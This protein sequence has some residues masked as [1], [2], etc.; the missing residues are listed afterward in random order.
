MG[1]LNVLMDCPLWAEGYEIQRTT[2]FDFRRRCVDTLRDECGVG[3]MNEATLA[4]ERNLFSTLFITT[5]LA[6]G[7]SAPKARFYAMANQCIRALVTG[8]DNLLDDE[9]KEVIQFDFSGSG[10]RFRSV[11]TVMVADRVLSDMA[12]DELAAGR[13]SRKQA[14]RL[15]RAVLGL[16]LP[17]GIEEHE[18]ESDTDGRV[19]SPDEMLTEVHQRKTGLLFQ[20]PIALLETMGELAPDQ[21]EPAMETLRNLGLACQALDDMKDIVPDL[22]RRRYNLVLSLAYHGD[23]PHERELVASCLQE[24]PRALETTRRAAAELKEA[25]S[26][27]GAIADDLFR[28]AEAGLMRLIP[29]FGRNQ[30]GALSSAIACAIQK[31]QRDL[32]RQPTCRGA[33][34]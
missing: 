19:P 13:F 1:S 27:C 5:S 29:R 23:V 15:T 25:G 7:V 4:P 18:E 17:S 16:L 12:A 14:K 2:L 32:R 6:L 24:G 20:A 21:T 8:C 9:F 22:R 10:T 30:A 11:L 34:R 3:P 31:G 26:R 33:R 28:E